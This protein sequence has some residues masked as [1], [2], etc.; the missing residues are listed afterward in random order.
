LRPKVQ[1]DIHTITP[2]GDATVEFRRKRTL[3]DEKF[4]QKY[5]QVPS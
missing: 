1:Q 5:L 4:C 2:T 3:P